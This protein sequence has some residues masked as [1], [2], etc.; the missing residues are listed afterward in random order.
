MRSPIP[1]LYSLNNAGLD[2]N[3]SF[4]RKAM[5]ILVSINRVKVM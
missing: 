3:F 1:D 2:F 4:A 5:R